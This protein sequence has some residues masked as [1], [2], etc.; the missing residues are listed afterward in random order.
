MAM[1]SEMSICKLIIE[2]N[3]EEQKL[4]PLQLT[5]LLVSLENLTAV[6]IG[7]YLSQGLI[8]T[9]NA[10]DNKRQQR[11]HTSIDIKRVEERVRELVDEQV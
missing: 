2:A 11:T 7:E 3:N 9:L 1:Q 6:Q 5:R 4:L 8:A 10:R